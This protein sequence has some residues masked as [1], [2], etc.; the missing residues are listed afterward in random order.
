MPEKEKITTEVHE[1]MLAMVK[2]KH[3]DVIAVLA[4]DDDFCKRG[5]DR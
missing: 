2:A 3:P 5:K 1:E 4:F